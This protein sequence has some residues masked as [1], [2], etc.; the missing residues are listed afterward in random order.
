M[1]TLIMYH[2][3]DLDGVLSGVIANYYI[4]ERA[5]PNDLIYLFPTDY[6][7]IEIKE[8]DYKNYDK[9]YVIDFSDDWLLTSEHKDKI[10]LIDHHRTCIDKNYPVNKFLEEGVAA[11]RL[12]LQFF[13]NIDYAFLSLSSYKD[14]NVV[15]PFFVTMAGEYDIWDEQS[16][17]SRLINFGVSSSL[18]FNYVDFIFR[19]TKHILSSPIQS[20]LNEKEREDFIR[21]HDSNI[22]ENN[23]LFLRI[24]EQGEGVL[25]YI[26][27]TEKSIKGVPIKLCGL[28][29]RAFNTHIRSSL[30]YN[31]KQDEDFILVWCYDGDSMIKV[32]MYSDKRDL[33]EIARTF[34]G[35]GHKKACGFRI[36]IH[37]LFLILGGKDIL[38]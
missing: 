9:I 20:K 5:N 27:K 4:K 2:G 14:R 15:E 25:S 11:C 36:A 1:K 38:R 34:G 12:A 13:T 3:A 6:G 29:G 16:R 35:G 17:Y 19:E 26:Q 21:V 7:D 18:A 8:V 10:I 33:H 37:E 28:N 30:I 24:C 32:S 23:S 22:I 31:L